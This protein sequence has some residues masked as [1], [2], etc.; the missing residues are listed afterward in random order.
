MKFKYIP[1]LFLAAATILPACNKDFLNQVPDDRISIDQV[2][3]RR[4]YTEAYLANIYSYMPND[5]YRN[6]SPW[7][8]MSDDADI[9]YD[10]PGSGY[11]TYATNLGN[12]NAA[13]NYFNYWT[14]F[15]KAIRSATYFI[16]RVDENEEIKALPNGNDLI[17]QY[18]A[19]ARALRA[20]YYYCI[21]RQYGPCILLG[22]TPIPGD[23]SPSAEE[24]NLP[25][26]SMDECIDYIVAELDAAAPLLP[27]HFTDQPDTEYGRL[28]QAFCKAV[29][30]RA[31]LHAASPLFNGNADYAMLKNKNGTQL[32]NQSY[33]VNKWKRAADAAKEMITGFSFDLYR[34]NG[35][36]GTFDPYLSTRDVFID[37][38]NIEVIYAR[39]TN[40]LSA[41]ERSASPRLCNGYA[42]VAVTQQLVDEFEMANGKGIKEA[43]SGYVETGFSTEEHPFAPKGT[44]NMYVNRE[45]RFYV[46]VSFNGSPW[47][48]PSEGVKLIQTYFTGNTGKK[49]SWDFP[50]TGYIARKN[51]HPDSN[52]RLSKYVARPLVIFRYAEILLNYIEAL[53][54][55][56]PGNPDI[57]L[58]LNKIRN[59]A[60]LPDVAPGLGQAEMR[61][62]I[63][64]E[65]RVELALE[66]MRYFDTRR[67]K[68]AEQTDG[69][70]FYGMN[71]D[72][73]TKLT[74]LVFYQRTVFERRVFLKQYYLF[75]IPQ[76]EMDRDPQLVQNTGW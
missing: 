16:N 3:A 39:P 48:N 56:E 47:I 72:A 24:M 38:W 70:P 68:I 43:G 29:K 12:W 18:K 8:G 34:K 75:P 6:T 26:N 10:R 30:S 64:H 1:L 32:I 74:D 5:A 65:R 11:D 21:V 60:G 57:A 19:E 40:S 52:P 45:P 71:V 49:G 15:Y 55:A 9:T 2:F 51:V 7:E 76:S 67:W 41:W 53:N 69:G 54:E 66:N 35:A 25:R 73:G 61:A 31:L 20:F 50:R 59:R 23:L 22:D 44:Y 46:N 28:T 13:S 37:P 17:A 36:G 14:S 42:A 4:K 33:D 62:K 27:K 58:Y 63:W